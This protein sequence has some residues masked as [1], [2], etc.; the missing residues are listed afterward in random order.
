[1]VYQV[2]VS[3]SAYFIL[4]PYTLYSK[5]SIRQGQSRFWSLAALM[6]DHERYPISTDASGPSCKD[7]SDKTLQHGSKRQDGGDL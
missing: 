5:I 4:G 2:T 7:V 1:M 3:S 6:Q